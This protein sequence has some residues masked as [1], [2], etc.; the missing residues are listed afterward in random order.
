MTGVSSRL[1]HHPVSAYRVDLRYPHGVRA[2]LYPHRNCIAG[3]GH[4]AKS[5]GRL[6]RLLEIAAHNEWHWAKQI[7]EFGPDCTEV[8]QYGPR[9]KMLEQ[10]AV[11]VYESPMTQSEAI[12]AT[13]RHRDC[14]PPCARVQAAVERL[15]D[16]FGP[17][18]AT[19]LR[20]PSRID[21]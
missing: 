13:V 2:L 6:Q 18:P 21:L 17:K 3:P 1:D 10:H 19:I 4:S 14:D 7:V 11:A 16:D 9:L 5:C 8:E 12:E 15:T 20:F